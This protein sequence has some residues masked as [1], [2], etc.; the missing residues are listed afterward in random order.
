MKFLI[1]ILLVGFSCF[2]L[3]FLSCK[4]NKDKNI[5]PSCGCSST[6]IQSQIR[7]LSG[8]LAY[9]SYTNKWFI[10]NQPTNGYFNNNFIC[11]LTQDSVK[12]I[13][14]NVPLSATFNVIFSGKVKS[15][16]SD[17]DFGIQQANG[18]NYHIIII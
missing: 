4:K 10:F 2:T 1:I 13:I 12:S 17:E 15:V 8:T 16:C 11:N 14:T 5:D 6:N 18:T 9:N 7:N 3:T